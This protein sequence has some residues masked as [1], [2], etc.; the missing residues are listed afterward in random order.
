MTNKY[1]AVHHKMKKTHN[2][3]K[4]YNMKSSSWL[5]VSLIVLALSIAIF[6]FG[7]LPN[8]LHP[9]DI[10]FGSLI[11]LGISIV[12]GWLFFVTRRTE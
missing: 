9:R 4:V 11:G 10:L 12:F 1:V 8:P 2:I 6:F 3:G 7:Y 5:S